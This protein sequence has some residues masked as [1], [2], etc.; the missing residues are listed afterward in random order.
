MGGGRPTM[1]AYA[2]MATSAGG[3]GP[4]YYSWVTASYIA[5]LVLPCTFVGSVTLRFSTCWAGCRAVS[6]AS[7]VTGS[8]QCFRVA[9][10]ARRGPLTM[11][12][13]STAH[14]CIAVFRMLDVS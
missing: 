3:K 2:R 1:P 12:R 13:V 14:S 11:A 5:S 4:L 6:Q 7:L 8:Q 10:R 9:R